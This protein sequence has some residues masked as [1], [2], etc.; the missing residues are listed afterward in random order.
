LK[1]KREDLEKSLFRLK[2][3]NETL[4]KELVTQLPHPHGHKRV[5]VVGKKAAAKR[6]EALMNVAAYGSIVV[7]FM[8]ITHLYTMVKGYCDVV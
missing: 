6:L 1:K 2:Q 7:Y 8:V 5:L 4:Q 3:G